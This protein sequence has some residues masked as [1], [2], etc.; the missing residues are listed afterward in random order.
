MK[1]SKLL[2][3]LVLTLETL[4][5][6]SRHCLVKQLLGKT[7]SHRLSFLRSHNRFKKFANTNT[8]KNNLK[9]CC[10]EQIWISNIFFRFTFLSVPWFLPLLLF[11]IIIIVSVINLYIIMINFILWLLFSYYYFLV[12]IY[13]LLLL[14]SFFFIFFINIFIV[15]FEFTLNNV[16]RLFGSFLSQFFL[17]LSTFK[18]L[19]FILCSQY[20]EFSFYLSDKNG[21]RTFT[22]C[23]VLRLLHLYFHIRL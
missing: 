7:Y 8:F 2:P 4:F 9:K 16:I 21:N 6:D 12:F 17:F 13:L 23:F 14:F 18:I 3:T 1:F 11:I 5:R 22:A 15:N 10:Y 19:H 20:Q